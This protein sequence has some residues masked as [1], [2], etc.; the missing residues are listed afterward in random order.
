MRI[1]L[2]VIL[3][4]VLILFTSVL[5][6]QE[7]RYFDTPFG[8]GGGYT[9][10]WYFPNLDPLNKELIEIGIPEL[11][12]SGFYSSGGAGFIYIGFVDYL[13]IGGLSFNGTT[14]E[15]SS[16]DVNGFIKEARYDLS[17]GGFTFEYSLPFI[18]NIAVSPGILLGAGS[19]KI[20]VYNNN[21]NFSWDNIWNETANASTENINH[22]L[23]NSFFIFA[24]TLNVDIPLYRF[25]SLRIGGGY[26]IT[27][28][29]EWELDNNKTIEGVPS[30][31]NGNSF[32]LQSGIF[33][34]FFSY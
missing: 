29:G 10:G 9:P 22:S 18:R 24:P 17:G 6:S 25:I 2:S 34:G 26:Q 19:L 23:S 3:F 32:F 8:G 14:S 31:L 15:V 27:F 28:G 30:D 11:S 33:I 21:D 16:R 1:K 5:F 20:D 4:I 13:R 7:K 12:E